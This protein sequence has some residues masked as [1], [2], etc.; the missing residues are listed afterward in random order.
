M[1]TLKTGGRKLP[2]IPDVQLKRSSPGAHA[3]PGKRDFDMERAAKVFKDVFGES[4]LYQD[5][6]EHLA[7][8]SQ[9]GSKEQWRKHAEAIRA[10]VK[11]GASFD[12]ETSSEDGREKIVTSHSTEDATRQHDAYQA[13]DGRLV[14]IQSHVGCTCSKQAARGISFSRGSWFGTFEHGWKDDA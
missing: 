7:R 2:G 1:H 8:S 4:A 13:R 11:R 14:K 10:K 12:V 6:I 5:L 9:T 3:E